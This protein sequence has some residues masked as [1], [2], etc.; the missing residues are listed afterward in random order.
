ML[1]FLTSIDSGITANGITR[2]IEALWGET[3]PTIF[4]QVTQKNRDLLHWCAVKNELIPLLSY[5]GSDCFIDYIAKT[6]SDVSSS[7]AR[8]TISTRFR[9]TLCNPQL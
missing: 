7:T 5:C 9:S 2:G 3:R 6:Y 8:I 1:D 4:N